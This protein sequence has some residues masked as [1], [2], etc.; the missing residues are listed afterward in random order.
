[1]GGQQ[2]EGGVAGSRGSRME[3]E[4][5]RESKVTSLSLNF[6]LYSIL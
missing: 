4:G 6:P 1:M 3:W 2:G 5:K